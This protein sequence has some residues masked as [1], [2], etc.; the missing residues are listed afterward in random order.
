MRNLELRDCQWS[1][2]LVLDYGQTF[3][4]G[5]RYRFLN[6]KTIVELRDCGQRY[7]YWFLTMV[8]ALTIVK[9]TGS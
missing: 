6:F 4:H 9:D 3:D 7:M 5:Q 1:K 8:K 2:I